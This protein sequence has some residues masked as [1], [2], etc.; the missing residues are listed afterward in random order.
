MLPEKQ[1]HGEWGGLFVLYVTSRDVWPST[2]LIRNR[3][4]KMEAPSEIRAKPKERAKFK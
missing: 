3:G 4:G 1:D 2:T